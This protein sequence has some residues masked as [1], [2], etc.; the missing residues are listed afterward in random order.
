[1]K[2]SVH[3]PKNEIERYY[4][5]AKFTILTA[6]IFKIADLLVKIVGR[7]TSSLPGT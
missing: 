4:F 5:K 2:E 7:N 1:M 6:S 3:H